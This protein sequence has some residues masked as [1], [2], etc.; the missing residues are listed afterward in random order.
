MVWNAGSKH[1]EG[2]D[3]LRLEICSSLKSGGFD[4]LAFESEHVKGGGGGG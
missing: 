4:G 1:I 2:V 3:N